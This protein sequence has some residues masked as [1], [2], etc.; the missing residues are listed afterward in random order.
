MSGLTPEKPVGKERKSQTNFYKAGL[1]RSGT[2]TVAI[3]REFGI[4][5]S[6]V[7]IN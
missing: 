6:K 4:S 5:K 7:F 2:L 3:T 1:A